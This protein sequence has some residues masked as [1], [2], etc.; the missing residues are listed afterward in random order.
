MTYFST[1]LT[2][3]YKNNSMNYDIFFQNENISGRSTPIKINSH[4]LW[5]NRLIVKRILL[6][7]PNYIY[8]QF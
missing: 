1:I 2:H 5:W 4:N 8:Y 6:S 3:F 7:W